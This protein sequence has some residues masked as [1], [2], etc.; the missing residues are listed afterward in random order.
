[1]VG[2]GFNVLIIDD[3][4]IISEEISKQLSR[5]AL[6]AYCYNIDVNKTKKEIVDEVV[7]LIENN[8]IGLEYIIADRGFICI[9]EQNGCLYRDTSVS[10]F[11]VDDII[12]Q[13]IV[14]INT[15]RLKN[16]TKFIIYTYDRFNS[17]VWDELKDLKQEIVDSFVNQGINLNRKTVEDRILT[18]ETSQTFKKPFSQQIYPDPNSNLIGSKEVVLEYAVF[19]YQILKDS[20]NETKNEHKIL[21]LYSY[22]RLSNYVFVQYLKNIN[23]LL[24]KISGDLNGFEVA[25]TSAFGNIFGKEEY[26]LDVP[27]KHYFEGIN[28]FI[29]EES[30]NTVFKVDTNFLRQYIVQFD[31]T[32]F[33]DDYI[34]IHHLG[35]YHEAKIVEYFDPNILKKWLP[36]L[37]YAIYYHSRPNI[38]REI[39]V[40]FSANESDLNQGI[41][42]SM[43]FVIDEVS[44][45]YFS[46]TMNFVL[47]REHVD[48][49]KV[50]NKNNVINQIH[51][52]LPIVKS[53]VF[54]LLLPV[55]HQEQ[56]NNALRSAISAIMGRNMSHNLGSHV[57]ATVAT[58]LNY[59]NFKDD[60]LLFK[61]LQHRMDFI[62]LISTE[63]PRWTIP[64]WFVKEMMKEFYGQRH[65][66]EYLGISEGISAYKYS[67]NNEPY[68]KLKIELCFNHRYVDGNDP[69][70]DKYLPIYDEVN[71]KE[72][73]KNKKKGTEHDF[74]L[75][76]PGGLIGQHA[77]FIILE[78]IIRNAAKHGYSAIKTEAEKQQKNLDI[79]IR[80]D[81]D[82]A[83]DHVRFTIFDKISNISCTEEASEQN[84]I[85]TEHSQEDKLPLHQRINA[86]LR[87]SLLDGNHKLRKADWGVNEM[88]ISAGYLQKCDIDII[89]AESDDNFKFFKAVAVKKEK[90]KG[91]HLGYEFTVPKPKEGL[92]VCPDLFREEKTH[93]KWKKES[94]YWETKQPNMADFE[95]CVFTDDKALF[96]Q[97]NGNNLSELIFK[98][99][100]S[101]VE[102]RAIENWLVTLP[103]RLFVVTNQIIPEN[104]ALSLHKR[105]VT[106]SEKEW[107]TFNYTN[108]DHP[109]KLKQFLYNT[110]IQHLKGLREIEGDITLI[111][112]PSGSDLSPENDHS[113]FEKVGLLPAPESTQSINCDNAE[114]IREKLGEELGLFKYSPSTIPGY[115]NRA[116]T[117][118]VY[119]NGKKEGL[120]SVHVVS[121]STIEVN[122]ELVISYERHEPVGINSKAI[123]AENLTGNAMHLNLL[124]SEQEGYIDFKI[125]CQCIE[126]GLLRIGIFD[127]RV[128]QSELMP[129]KTG[130][131]DYIGLLKR[132]GVYV[133]NSCHQV[134]GEDKQIH[135]GKKRTND[136]SIDLEANGMVSVSETFKSGSKSRS[137][138]SNVQLDVLIIHQ[139]LIDK[140]STSKKRGSNKK[141]FAE[142][143]VSKLKQNIPNVIV[144]TGRGMPDD[145]PNNAKYLPFSSVESY[146]LNLPHHKFILCQNLLSLVANR[147]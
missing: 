16:L 58:Q 77:F 104:N 2:Q 100:H 57:I 82:P 133:I 44:K 127:E 115:L 117:E 120:T 85:P 50:T 75:A 110:W 93:M 103:G 5:H 55:V 135:I 88:R 42:F 130:E 116:K 48:K 122:E 132:S 1:M 67:G 31:Y 68:G 56:V 9:Y 136:W 4:Q 28:S 128:C 12:C 81:N 79:C 129:K 19:L 29:D 95:F 70:V 101:P 65:L 121:K 87:K 69:T 145:L 140:I 35:Q 59:I 7:F 54:D 6:T 22:Q 60:Q 119:R 139:G 34:E 45:A 143:F 92:V 96:Y 134:W 144:T 126:N 106:V 97:D 90:G 147:S 105:I 3:V 108:A 40:Q 111:L 123:Y 112:N 72:N 37:H 113:L 30:L 41:E 13:I 78:G 74:Q 107:D 51:S 125:I 99:D 94:V 32:L 43:Y 53:K 23:S 61:Y 142:S 83:E 47:I 17:L 63:F 89:G 52:L 20:I 80:I 109:E 36:L 98:T 102:A 84:Y 10:A 38:W 46:G 24:N 8:P 49:P 21:S 86:K 18:I 131:M 66:L 14:R 33:N 137:E 27:Y 64:S 73:S 11:K 26:L 15:N 76:I 91:Y 138:K 114:N 146:L 118:K 124:T 71:E 141:D 25:S 62:A 39:N